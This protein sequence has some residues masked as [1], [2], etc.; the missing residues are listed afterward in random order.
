MEGLIELVAA[1]FIKNGIECPT[2]GPNT[3]WTSPAE[4]KPATALPEHSFRK[5]SE[6]EVAT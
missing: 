6:V 3:K 2:G 1:S 4:P 5:N